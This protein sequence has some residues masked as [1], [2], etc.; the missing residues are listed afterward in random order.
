MNLNNEQQR[1][2][3]SPKKDDL[4]KKGCLYDQVCR[5]SLSSVLT[6]NAAHG[7]VFP[8]CLEYG[9][10]SATCSTFGSSTI[11]KIGTL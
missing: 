9:T 10:D 11:M 2:Q 5:V 6:G 1:Q 3:F 7:W 8:A 4:F